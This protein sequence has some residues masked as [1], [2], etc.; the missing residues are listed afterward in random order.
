MSS[1]II[2]RDR[3]DLMKLPAFCDQVT[4]SSDQPCVWENRYHNPEGDVS[5]SDR[6]S[7][8][9]EDDCP[10]TGK[11]FPPEETVWAGPEDRLSRGLWEAL[12]ERGE[13]EAMIRVVVDGQEARLD[14]G[15]AIT[16]IEAPVAVRAGP[17]P[18]FDAFVRAKRPELA[19]DA[20]VYM[21]DVGAR[22]RGWVSLAAG[23]VDPDTNKLVR[24]TGV[25]IRADKDELSRFCEAW[26]A[27]N[28]PPEPEPEPGAP[29]V[30]GP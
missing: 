2:L 19:G 13:G 3:S 15:W 14:E 25:Q 24:G 7:C 23:R 9:C 28:V 27:A 12:P 6:W 18:D 22:D 20:I 5:W 30:D 17:W 21:A 10:E 16:G 11:G 1:I 8:A 4:D 26:A 29:G